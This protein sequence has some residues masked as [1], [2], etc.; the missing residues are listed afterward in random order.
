MKIYTV[1][2]DSGQTFD[3]NGK[4]I[5]LSLITDYPKSGIIKL[6][7]NI[8]DGSFP[9]NIRIPNFAQDF[10]VMIN[11]S[12]AMGEKKKNY[13]RMENIFDNDEITVSFTIKPRIVYANPKVHYNCG[14]IAIVRGPEVFCFEECDNSENLASLSLD[15]KSP[16]IENWQD[17]LLGGLMMIKAKG[18]KLIEPAE[19][20]SFSEKYIPRYR[21]V[22]LTAVPYGYWCNR[23][24]G[25]M[26]V[27]IR[28][29]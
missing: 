3:L 11:G 10:S 13:F 12:P 28:A 17:D 6:K 22:D 14:K 15:T 26:L 16:L 9:L 23:T 4:S 5:R 8:N 20:D 7:V 25:D 24:P 1:K 29:E 21:D 18:K 2:G 27:W 19:P